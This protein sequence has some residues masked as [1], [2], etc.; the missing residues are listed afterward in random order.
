MD[1]ITRKVYLA[2]SGSF[3]IGFGMGSN[4]A[5]AILDYLN[6][7]YGTGLT[8]Q[9]AYTLPR[10]DNTT[11]AHMAIEFPQSRA[12]AEFLG[13]PY[14]EDVCITTYEIPFPEETNKL[15]SLEKENARL[16]QQCHGHDTRRAAAM[17][18]ASE[19]AS[20]VERLTALLAAQGIDHA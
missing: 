4:P 8:V 7:V 5:M 13:V 9:I 18:Q 19:L 6:K 2:E 16:V 17:L 10:P 12:E 14:M 11:L 3:E 1:T 20:E 15:E